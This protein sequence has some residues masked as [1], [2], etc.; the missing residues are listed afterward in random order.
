[1]KVCYIALLWDIILCQSFICEFWG[2]YKGD[3]NPCK[4]YSNMGISKCYFICWDSQMLKNVYYS[5]HTFKHDIIIFMDCLHAPFHQSV[6]S[7]IVYM[8]HSTN[9]YLHRLFTCL[10]PPIS[11][12][13][14]CLHAPFYQSV[15]SW[16]VYM[17]HSTNQY[18]HGLFTCPIPP[19]SIFMD[20]LHAPFHQSV[21]SW[22]VYTSQCTY[23]TFLIVISI[24]K[25]MH[26]LFT[27][28]NL[29]CHWR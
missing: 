25:C 26:I 6:S 27:D 12:F 16:I 8:P 19:I 17:P 13:M 10:I 2:L 9:Q 11:I 23:Q 14:D 20:C 1:M 29:P 22:I 4:S 15:S 18:L 28:L 24:H 3:F 7:W 21:S 5:Y